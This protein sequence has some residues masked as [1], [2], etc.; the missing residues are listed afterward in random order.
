MDRDFDLLKFRTPKRYWS[1]THRSV[2]PKETW[3]RIAPLLPRFGITRV[4]DIT[5][6]DRIGIPVATA[7]RP[8]SRS[9][10]VAAGKGVDL[11]AA[12]VSA[13]MEAIECAHAE[14]IDHPL[15][16]AARSE[17]SQ[18][19]RTVE[20]E[21]LPLLRGYG[22]TEQSRLL[23]IEGRELGD[24]SPVMLPYDLVHA[25]YCPPA[26]PHSGAFLATTNGLSSGNVMAEA[27]SH[28]LFEIIE[29]DALNLWSRRSASARAERF[30]DLDA[31]EPGNS[32]AGETVERLK[33][34]GFEVALWDI[35]SDV[36]V[37]A[38]HCI[39][40]D[41]ADPDGH[42]GTGTGCHPDKNVALARAL[43]EAVQVR[44]IYI[45]G[46]RDDLYR[47]EYEAEHMRSFRSAIGRP[48]GGGEAAPRRFSELPS[49]S[50]EHFE[51][52]LLWALDNLSAAGCN[53]VITIDLSQPGSGIAVVRVVVPRLEGP[54]S[55]N[56]ELGVRAM[57]AS[58]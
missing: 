53:S 11:V 40:V 9:V 18:N 13:A 15:I 23:W 39:I 45:S 22:L 16:L 47:R 2:P 17:I 21:N 56:A 5:G 46:G 48:P 41:A 35:A 49:R 28:A 43:F 51:D 57:R 12:K 32:L 55:D 31:T 54:L 19:R 6:L 33:H 27:V 14:H 52:D 4:A 7:I 38:F 58:S 37:P 26:L 44:A 10:A 1:G 29:R 30:V 34:A 3:E 50:A 8:L 25:H 36:G 20:L 42:P 24:G